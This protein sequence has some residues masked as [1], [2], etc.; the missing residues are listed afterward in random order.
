MR[1]AARKTTVFPARSR[2]T[3]ELLDAGYTAYTVNLWEEDGALVP[4]AALASEKAYPTCPVNVT[5]GYYSEGNGA[6]YLVSGSLVYRLNK[7]GTAYTTVARNL[8]DGAFFADM[9]VEGSAST[10]LFDGYNR[11]TYSGQAQSTAVADKRFYAGAEHCGRLFARDYDE[12]YKLWWSASDAFDWEEGISGSGYVYLPAAGGEVLRLFSYRERLIAVRRRGITVV[13]AYGDPENYKVGATANYLTA[14]GIIERTCAVCAGDIYFCTEGG[15]Y[16]FNGS[17]VE[18][19]MDFGGRISSPQSAAACG[20]RYYLICTDKYLG[21]GCVLCFDGLKKRCAVCD[22]KP[23][24]LF[25]A[26]QGVCA[27][28]GTGVYKILP[29]SGSGR[30]V[31]LPFRIE[32]SRSALIKNISAACGGDIV[33]KVSAGGYERTFSCGDI[34]GANISGGTFVFDVDV[35]G[36]LRSLR[37]EAE[38]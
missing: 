23:S 9:Y 24:A 11:I 30:W 18:K 6:L 31:S 22:I 38:I 21:G 13:H 5:G 34:R 25:A 20:E 14:D 37:V 7:G 10:V 19:L 2:K 35:N 15:L 36:A 1:I 17:S 28:V 29:C 32:G 16:A 33:I 27:V 3:A 8:S 12:P 4:A 26:E